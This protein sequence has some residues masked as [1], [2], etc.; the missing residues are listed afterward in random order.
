MYQVFN[1]SMSNCPYK[2]VNRQS[3][4]A[5]GCAGLDNTVQ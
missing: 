5:H 2:Y 4:T 1:Q 3:L